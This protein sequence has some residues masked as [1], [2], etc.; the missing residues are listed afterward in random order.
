MVKICRFQEA[1][2][3]R[4]QDSRHMKV[5]RLSAL[6]TGRLYPPENIPGT[7][8][9]ERLSQP[10]GHSVAGGIM[11]MKNSSDTTGN[12][13]RD[14]PIC[15]AVALPTAP[16]CTPISLY[17]SPIF[18][19]FFLSREVLPSPFLELYHQFQVSHCSDRLHSSDLWQYHSN[20]PFPMTDNFCTDLTLQV[21]SP[22]SIYPCLGSFKKN[23][24]CPR[25]CVTFQNPFFFFGKEM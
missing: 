17:K 3:P 6:R 11:S 8:F 5:V 24:S 7:H 10:Q 1:E 16:P 19:L 23:L 9:C 18:L 20:P 2:A 14:L 22:I 4:F 21:T 13:T 12:R 15:N 25:N